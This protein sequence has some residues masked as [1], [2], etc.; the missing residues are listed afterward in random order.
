MLEGQLMI[1]I[2]LAK[3]PNTPYEVLAQLAKD[4]D[5]LVREQIAIRSFSKTS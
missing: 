4:K 2:I 1:T 3:N 5:G